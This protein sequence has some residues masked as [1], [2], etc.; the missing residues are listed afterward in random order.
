MDLVDRKGIKSIVLTL[1]LGFNASLF[2]ECEVS[3]DVNGTGTLSLPCVD[4]LNADTRT[5]VSAEL[6]LVD[7]QNLLFEL[8][9][10]SALATLPSVT[11]AIF[12]TPTT[13]LS[14]PLLKVISGSTSQDY[15]ITMA[16]NQSGLFH[17]SEAIPVLATANNIPIVSD[18]SL[19]ADSDLPYQEINLIATD[20]DGDTLVY[21]LLSSGSGSGYTLAYINPLVAKIYVTLDAGFTG[22]V[23][24]SY[25][26]SDGTNFSNPGAISISVG[27]SSEAHGTGL[28]DVDAQTY[29]QYSTSYLDSGLLGAP[30]APPTLPSAIDLSAGF[31]VPGNQGQQNSCVGWATAYALKS[32]Q[33]QAENQWSLNTI[34][35]LF[36][37]SFIY[38]QINRGK[39]VGSL[40]SEALDLIVNSGAATLNTMGYSDADYLS[41]PS[42]AAISEAANYKGK[43]WNVPRSIN[44]MKAALANSLP[45]VIG[46][47]IFAS[48]NQ[49]SGQDAVYNSAS[50]QPLGGHA[51]TVVGYDDNKYG[52][53]FKVINSY[54]QSWGD[55]GYFWLPYSFAISTPAG[56][57]RPLMSVAFVLKDADNANSTTTPTGP[58]TITEPPPTGNLVNFEIQNWN[59]SYDGRPG[60]AGS[61][62]YKVVNTGAGT[63]P[64]GSYIALVLSKDSEMTSNDS[65]VVYEQIPFDLTTGEFVFRDDSN[66]ISFNLPSQLESGTYYAALWVDVLNQFKESNENDNISLSSNTLFI[67]NNFADLEVG[68]WYA[69]WDAFGFGTLTYQI[70]NVGGGQAASGWD[71]NLVLSS[72]ATIGNGDEVSLFT[73]YASQPLDPGGFFYRDQTNFATFNLNTLANGFSVP[74]GVY[75]MALWVNAN[76]AVSESVTNNNFSMGGNLIGINSNRSTQHSG[77]SYNGRVLPTQVVRQRVEVVENNG[78]RSL[79]LLDRVKEVKPLPKQVRAANQ[80][81]F[82]LTNGKAMPV[83]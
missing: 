61:L 81:I 29:S 44:D 56:Q 72:D 75:Y 70:N 8:Q 39:D 48:F 66:A 38:N 62:Q 10:Y 63:A 28:N 11:G 47:D 46:I 53:A 58:T 3:Y 32:Y 30:G 60:G 14:I 34:D 25:R 15:S 20:S 69:Y 49:V 78:R 41:Q 71:L 36:S 76:N 37:P 40:P 18:I 45:V 1:L 82:P 7:A 13:I 68:S 73:E 77:S 31:P 79:R 64:S 17:V 24:L 2:A 42:A 6:Q 50:G 55:N 16:L 12:D 26:A 19:A 80:R 4:L 57:S 83:R 21:E 22:N 65:L 59:L 33:E 43:S 51:V 5:V 74:S 52:G 9:S 67:A 27:A 35:H 54:G 23:A